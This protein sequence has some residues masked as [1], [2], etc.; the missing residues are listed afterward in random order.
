MDPVTIGAVLLAI[1]TGTSEALGGQLW[2]SVV[3]LVRRP[4]RRKAAAGADVAVAVSSG[5][6][7][8]P[9]EIA[10]AI[11]KVQ[12]KALEDAKRR[13]EK[14]VAQDLS[15]TGVVDRPG[16]GSND[17]G[18][19]DRK[20]KDTVQDA[21][22]ELVVIEPDIFVFPWSR[23]SKFMALA[24]EEPKWLIEGIWTA[25]SQGILGGEPKT[26]KTTLGLALA[27]SV[28]SG[29]SLFGNPDYRVRDQGPVLFVQEENAPW[30]IQDR[31]KKLAH[32]Y[33]I[34][35][36]IVEKRAPRGSLGK[37]V[38]DIVFPED[39]PLKLLNNYGLDLTQEDHREAIWKEVEQFKPRLVVLDP[40]YMIMAGVNFDK[41]HEL[42]PYL[43][44]LLALSNEFKCAVCII[45]H[46]RKAQPG[47]NTRPGQR[48]M[49]NATL[50]GFVD[51]AL[52]CEQIDADDRR[53]TGTLYTR[54]HREFR[55]IEPQKS[56]EFGIKMNPPGELGMSVE[57][58]TYDLSA[59]IV[60]LVNEQ[61]GVYARSL[62]KETGI[63]YRIL[64]GRARDSER[65]KLSAIKRGRGTS[66]RLYPRDFNGNT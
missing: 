53:R 8:S 18:T 30:M 6:A 25:E 56:L 39:I 50:H 47:N 11:R 44:W 13:K 41:A 19:G 54:V 63:D 35:G 32:M 5:E 22:G 15:G 48:L 42:A 59:R 24:M 49:G 37:Y 29:K 7:R 31:M 57:V 58:N 16:D 43:K 12:S 14:A 61:P 38:Y 2:A 10:K 9:N 52:Y 66:Y 51:S 34:L 46:F 21:S 33:G 1:I 45:H 20:I 40:L 65:I 27:M 62:S 4:L 26:S 23:Y 36:S 28:A 60:D 3:S 17:L 64:I 55:S